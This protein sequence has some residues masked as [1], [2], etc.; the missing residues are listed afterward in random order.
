[1]K[2]IA[3]KVNLYQEQFHPEKETLTIT[4]CLFAI[5]IVVG[6]IAGLSWNKVMELQHIEEEVSGLNAKNDTMM[7]QLS[8]L[9][10]ANNKN[11]NKAVKEDEIEGK[12]TEL[13]TRRELLGSL[14]EQK[15]GSTDGF[16]EFM[17]ALSRQH[18][19]GAWITGLSVNRG[20]EDLAITGSSLK[21]ELAPIY[22]QKLSNEKIFAGKSFAMLNLRQK[23]NI[24]SAVSQSTSD[25]EKIDFIFRTENGSV[26]VFEDVKL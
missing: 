22:L 11:K 14:T 26:P 5:F 10:I 23:E 24:S 21:P 4:N 19:Q 12:E 20:G 1:M 13:K 15:Y 6:V 9:A 8:T 25:S 17:V 18:V 7:E 2:L 16:S 3:Q